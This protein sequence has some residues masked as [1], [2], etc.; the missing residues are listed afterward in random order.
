MGNVS[1]KDANNTYCPKCE[2]L[3]IERSGFY[4]VNNYLQNGKCKCGER[5]PGIW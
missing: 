4:I 2:E 1:T 3:L 5:I